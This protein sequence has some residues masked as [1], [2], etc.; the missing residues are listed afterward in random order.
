MSEASRRA[1]RTLAQLVAS[2]VLTAL[3]NTL[4]GGMTPEQATV[5]LAVWQCIVTFAHNWLEDN[6]SF[7]TLLKTPSDPPSAGMGDPPEPG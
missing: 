3:V 2:G 4:V 7:P 6:T 1:A 5:V